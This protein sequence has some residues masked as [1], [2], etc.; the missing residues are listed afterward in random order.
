MP[1]LSPID[2]AIIARKLYKECGTDNVRAQTLIHTYGLTR[3]QK[4][5]VMDLYQ[6]HVQWNAEKFRESELIEDQRRL[7]Q[8]LFVQHEAAFDLPIT[9]K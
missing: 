2:L 5:R 9:E 8:E 7:A 4:R 6:G 1:S 3:S